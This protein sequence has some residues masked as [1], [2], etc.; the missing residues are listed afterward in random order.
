MTQ[1]VQQFVCVC[2]RQGPRACGII[3]CATK[4][5]SEGLAT[6]LQV[7]MSCVFSLDGT[8]LHSQFCSACCMHIGEPTCPLDAAQAAMRI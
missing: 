1:K 2:R 4:K 5:D 3:Y 8:S 7:H 6:F